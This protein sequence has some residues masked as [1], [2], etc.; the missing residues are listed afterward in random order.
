MNA[1][2]NPA[3]WDMVATLTNAG[4]VVPPLGAT[5]PS[6]IQALDALHWCSRRV[7]ELYL[8]RR[9][10]IARDL[11]DNGPAFALEHVL[12]VLSLV[13]TS[14]CGQVAYFLQLGLFDPN[15]DPDRERADLNAAFHEVA[16]VW[17]GRTIAAEASGKVRWLVYNSFGSLGIVDIGAL[18]AGTDFDSVNEQIEDGTPLA[19]IVERYDDESTPPRRGANRAVARKRITPRKSAEPRARV[20]PKPPGITEITPHLA[21]ALRRLEDDSHLVISVH[22]SMRYVQF[23]TFRPNLRLET[24]G[25]R[26]LDEAKEAWSVDELLW[27]ADHEWHDADDGGNL[28]R[29]WI[30][31][32][33]VAAAAAAVE[34]LVNVHGVTRLAQVWFQSEDD[35]AL[36]ALESCT[37]PSGEGRPVELPSGATVVAVVD[38]VTNN[39]VLEVLALADGRAVRRHDGGWYPDPEWADALPK[40]PSRSIVVLTPEL[41]DRVVPRVDASTAQ[42]PW[43]PFKISSLEMYWPSYRPNDP[44]LFDWSTIGHDPEGPRP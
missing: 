19:E 30:P 9:E 14:P 41:L 12:K 35:D 29:Q 16:Q 37:K 13:T 15:D 17:A 44:D 22:G 3:A 7:D 1:S 11:A 6:D 36:T 4:L 31:A 20:R 34:A 32:D 10:L 39:S 42:E 8:A 38:Y 40:A 33:E 27:L 23:A 43:K 26:Y 18:R 24:V 2:S 28:W 25:T 5:D 21:E